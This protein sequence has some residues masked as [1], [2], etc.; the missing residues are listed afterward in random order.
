MIWPKK[1]IKALLEKGAIFAIQDG[2]HGEI[3]PKSSDYVPSGIPF[4]MASDLT[5]NTLDL[6]NC[7]F[8][9]EDVASRLRK[10]FTKTGDVLLTHKGTL[11]LSDVVPE[12]STPYLM[13]TPQVTYYRLN[14]EK[15]KGKFLRYVFLSSFFQSQLF[16]LA[17]SGTRPYIGITA[18]RELE[19]YYP[20][21]D[22]QEHIVYLLSRYDESIAVN[23]R[24]IK[25][26]EEAARRLYREWF[27]HLRF[28]GHENVP[29]KD[30]VPEGWRKMSLGDLAEVV[31]GQSPKSEYYNENQQGLPF[32]QGVSNFGKRFVS[33]KVFTTQ[34]NREAN[35]GDILFSVRA[36]VGRINITRNIIAI[37][38]GLSA[39]RSKMNMQSLLFYQLDNY[40]SQEDM[41]G[42]GAIFASVGKKELLS[43]E[44][45]QP[46]DDI[47][48][49]F[50]SLVGKI[51][52]QI[53]CLSQQNEKL[54]QARDQ[55]LPRLMSGK[56]DVSQLPV[57]PMF[58]EAV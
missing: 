37:G 41:I 18:Q 31:M 26:L 25:L 30:G 50:D 6:G 11:G 45:L 21:I 2:N 51:D 29:V 14:P 44:L 32:H 8:I 16:S 4:V 38:R 55:L 36:P 40:F 3:H 20:S 57:E 5:G 7:K 47:A 13:L 52:N 19:I 9:S 12:I 23:R 33:D 10:G 1:S 49:S 17:R 24:R 42:G 28:P 39:M 15:L 34:H 53:N 22:V 35:A 27:V 46:T 56:L 54:K 58:D 48:H 43:Q